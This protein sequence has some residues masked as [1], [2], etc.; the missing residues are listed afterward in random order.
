MKSRIRMRRHRA[1]NQTSETSTHQQS[2]DALRNGCVTVP[3]SS[4]L[5][6]SPDQT[7]PD[8]KNT[9]AGASVSSEPASPASEPTPSPPSKEKIILT[10]PT[11]GKGAKEWHLSEGKLREY[12]EA[13]PGVDALAECR[14]AL[15]WCR[16][17]TPKRKTPRGM[18][19]FLTRW[20]TKAQN[21]GGARASGAAAPTVD[22]QERQRRNQEKTRRLRE[23]QSQAQAAP[24]GPTLMERFNARSADNGR[25][26]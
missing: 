8:Q 21:S 7:R 23:E 11:V 15:Q 6:R 10:Y 18:A 5:L 3:N 12:Q 25:A 26:T 22:E 13:F 24:A 16:D 4:E 19:A 2:T 20:L 14:A 9:D 1:K 17:N